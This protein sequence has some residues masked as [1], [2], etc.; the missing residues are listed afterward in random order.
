MSEFMHDTKHGHI[1]F[2][3]PFKWSV[4][5]RLSDPTV[6]VTQP[7]KWPNLAYFSRKKTW[8]RVT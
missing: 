2:L 3:R 8:G 1:G 5:N 7:I 6:Y 4:I